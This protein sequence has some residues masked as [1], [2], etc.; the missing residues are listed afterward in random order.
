MINKQVMNNQR[1][2]TNVKTI[3]DL[4]SKKL[5]QVMAKK[6]KFNLESKKKVHV[7]N[8]K[9]DSDILYKPYVTVTTLKLKRG[10]K[11]CEE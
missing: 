3:V 11:L 10:I 1:K 7:R 5:E 4:V 6:A 8:S 9:L 2:L